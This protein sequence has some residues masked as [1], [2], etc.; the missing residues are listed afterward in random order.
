MVL[1]FSIPSHVGGL[2][3]MWQILYSTMP[4]PMNYF[5]KTIRGLF[6]AGIIHCIGFLCK[7]VPIFS[8]QNP[9]SSLS[10]FKGLKV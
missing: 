10:S 8:L 9:K 6:L 7:I 2:I 4:S 3:G 1:Q 5:R